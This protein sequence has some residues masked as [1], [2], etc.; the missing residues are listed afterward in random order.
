VEKRSERGYIADGGGVLGTRERAEA[1]GP[2]L[3]DVLVALRQLD[4]RLE[5]AMAAAET[6]FGIAPDVAELRGLYIDQ[7]EVRRLLGHDPGEV[8]WQAVP[9]IGD[10]S[11]LPASEP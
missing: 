5:R 3:S 2:E 1:A 8:P 4:R 11:L 7:D 9:V 10:A 6:A